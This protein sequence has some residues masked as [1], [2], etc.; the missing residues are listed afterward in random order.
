M[1][2]A[3]SALMA[4]LSFGHAGHAASAATPASHRGGWTLHARQ[5]GFTGQTSCRLVRGHA[6]WRRGAVTFHLGGNVDTS[7]AVYRIDDGPAMTAASDQPAVAALGF[8]IWRDDLANPSAGVVRI[9]AEKLASAHL[10]RIEAHIGRVY[11]F[12]VDGLTAAVEAAK[13]KGCA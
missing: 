13:A 10:V 8:A 2:I 9:P 1:Q 11:G 6:E 12:G 5:D 3:L 4:V 7:G